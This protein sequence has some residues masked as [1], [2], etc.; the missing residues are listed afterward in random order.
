M[1]MIRTGNG[2]AF[3]DVSIIFSNFAGRPDK[4]NAEG[5]RNFCII[6]D[7]KE[8]ADILARDGYNV[9]TLRPRDD[10]D[11]PAYYLQVKVSLESRRPPHIYMVTSKARVSIDKN[12]IDTL[13]SADI[14]SADV[15][16]RPFEWEP[17]RISAYLGEMYVT[18][19]EDYFGGKYAKYD[20]P[21]DDEDVPF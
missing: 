5:K 20:D 1:R 19:A 14:I 13:D 12:R 17:G 7:S 8:D 9:K 2:Y 21:V 16:I 18:I 3:E 11:E 15:V 6:I 10:G 4:F